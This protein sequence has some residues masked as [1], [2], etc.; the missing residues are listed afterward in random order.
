M[1][2]KKQQNRNEFYFIEMTVLV[3][4][5]SRM[6]GIHIDDSKNND[7]IRNVQYLHF[8]SS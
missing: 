4:N 3:I 8:P 5:M 7:L 1:N 6:N 2:E